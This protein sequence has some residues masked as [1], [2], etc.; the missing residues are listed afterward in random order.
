MCSLSTLRFSIE[1]LTTLYYHCSV[2]CL[3]MCTL[4]PQGRNHFYGAH[5]WTLSSQQNASY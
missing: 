5:Q 2:T 1:A 3:H 4:I